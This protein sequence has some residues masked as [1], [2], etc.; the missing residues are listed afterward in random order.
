MFLWDRR[1]NERT[2]NTHLRRSSNEA[3]AL[4]TNFEHPAVVLQG[5]E[6]FGNARCSVGSRV[7]AEGTELEACVKACPTQWHTAAA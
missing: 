2:G 6:G 7:V 1:G 3:T 4:E 5:E